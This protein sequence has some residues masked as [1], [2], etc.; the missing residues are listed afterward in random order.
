MKCLASSW[1]VNLQQILYGRPT[2]WSSSWRSALSSLALWIM[3]TANLYGQKPMLP[4][5]AVID[6]LTL[7]KMRAHADHAFPDFGFERYQLVGMEV[8][9]TS[10]PLRGLACRSAMR[11]SSDLRYRQSHY[12][13]YR[14]K[15]SPHP[16]TI[17]LGR[18][19][20]SRGSSSRA[21]IHI[22]H[23]AF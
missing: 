20:Y 7:T 16:R 21:E 8:P 9:C 23:R 19:Q 3:A 15:R 22:L 13:V 5:T 14:H 4:G 18:E 1:I 17:R 12:L 2:N 11:L 6:N 10:R